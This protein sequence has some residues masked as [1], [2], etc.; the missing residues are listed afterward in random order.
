MADDF[1][2]GFYM[3]CERVSTEWLGDHSYHAE[4]VAQMRGI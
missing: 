2:M 1:D 4:Q 3:K